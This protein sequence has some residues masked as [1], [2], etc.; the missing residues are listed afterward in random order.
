MPHLS[1]KARRA[2]HRRRR[3]SPKKASRASTRRR[4]AALRPSRAARTLT[5][6]RSPSP[7]SISEPR[8]ELINLNT[9]PAPRAPTRSL[10]VSGFVRPLKTKKVVK[11]LSAFGT[12][13][14]FWIDALKSFCLV[15]VSLPPNQPVRDG[16]RGRGVPPE[17][18]RQGVAR[19]AVPREEDLRAPRGDGLRGQGLEGR[20]G[21]GA[22]RPRRAAL[23]EPRQRARDRRAALFSARRRRRGRG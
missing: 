9:V 19:A 14:R 18:L 6:R 1:E 12:V 23:G 8:A 13:E 16:D 4:R 17:G 7:V 2:R 11:M 5:R 15:T 21:P 3:I 22:G 10:R 20:G